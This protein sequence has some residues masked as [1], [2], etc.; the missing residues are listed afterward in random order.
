MSPE[1]SNLAARMPAGELP[2]EVAAQLLQSGDPS[3]ALAAADHPEI[4]AE[5]IDQ[6]AASEDPLMRCVAAAC[7]RA[8]AQTLLRLSKDPDV[9]VREGVASNVNTP[10]DALALLYG[11]PHLRPALLANHALPQNLLSDTPCDDVSEAVVVGYLCWRVTGRLGAPNAADFNRVNTQE[12]VS[13]NPGETLS[14]YAT[15]ARF[16]HT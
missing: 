6:L 5:A 14:A 16:A 2:V 12:R 1:D 4:P 15:R 8:S 13:P 9:R 10:Q 11:D 7:S 3:A